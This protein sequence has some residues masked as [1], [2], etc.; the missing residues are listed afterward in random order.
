MMEMRPYQREGVDALWNYFRSGKKGNPLLEY[1]TGCHA[2][3]HGIM[4]ADGSITRV[5]DVR[6]GDKLMGPDSRPRTVLALAR[7]RHVMRR[8]VPTRGES[9][10]VN[11]DHKLNVCRLSETGKARSFE[12]ITIR[13]YEAGSKN[14]RHLR[15]LRRVSIDLPHREQPLR[16]RFVGLMLGDG[17]MAYGLS[18]TSA[19]S[20]LHAYCRSVA[21]GFGIVCREEA[22]PDNLAWTTHFPHPDSTRS[23]PNPLTEVFR[24]LGMWGL[25]AWEKRIPDVY[26]RASRV[27]RLQLLAGL[28]DSDG[29]ISDNNAASYCTTSEGLAQDV[30]YLCRSLGFGATMSSKIAT[31]KGEPKRRAYT[32][33][34][35][36][37][38]GVIPFLRA[39]HVLREW[40]GNRDPLVTAFTTHALPEDDYYGFTLDGDKLYIDEYFNVHHN[41]GKS[42]VIAGFIKEAIER[43][44]RTRITNL[45]DSKHLVGQNAAKLA[46][47]WDG[48]I[49][50][51]SAGLDRKELGS[52]VTFAGTQSVYSKPHVLGHQDMVIVD[53]C[54]M[55]D[56]K[57]KRMYHA[58]LMGMLR[59]NPK[60]R[61]IGLTATPWRQGV[62]H[63]LNGG[64]FTETIYSRIGVDDFNEFVREGYLAD[65]RAIE[66]DTVIDTSKVSTVGGDF[67]MDQLQAASDKEEITRAA[68]E[69]SINNA[70][71]RKFWLVFATGC[72]HVDHVVDMLRSYGISAMGVHSKKSEAENDLAIQM[73]QSGQI[74]ALVNMG[75]LTKGFDAPHTTYIMMLRATKSAVLWVQMLGR[76]TRPKPAWAGHIDCLVGDFGGNSSRLGPINDPL[77]PRK[78]GEDGSGEAPVR[79]CPK[80]VSAGEKVGCGTYYHA[81]LRQCPH[82]G[83][84]APPAKSKLTRKASGADVVRRA[85]E[86]SEMPEIHT[87]PVHS[88]SYAIHRKIGKPD[89]VRVTYGSG[90]RMFSEYLCFEHE[91]FAQ[92]QAQKW[93]RERAERMSL[94]HSM[95]ATA[96]DALAA[97]GE[98]PPAT[99]IRVQV[100]LE[101]PR[102][103]LHCFD[104]TGWGEGDGTIHVPEIAIGARVSGP[105]ITLDELMPKGITED[106]I[107]F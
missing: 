49:G 36:G 14:Y 31:I 54:H 11:L 13:D 8:I 58:L 22:K 81:S 46:S 35:S 102:V 72:E 15:K 86:G 26:L 77:I 91:G 76:G 85:K 9:F 7:G 89:M 61:V 57:P 3:G 88:I 53:E 21:E 73:Y 42:V 43:Y 32:I 71:D 16:P 106:D 105:A 97:I 104:G 62:G 65:L 64:L 20:E 52:S 56:W 47:M 27:Q 2:A 95:P 98:F 75:V 55:I 83:K 33:H 63:I 93:W 92:R 69:E 24:S 1:P 17:S 44:P 66:T 29:Y 25:R 50:I 90:P 28:W 38:F 107:P 30:L 96:A 68:I 60:L 48:D 41:T 101:Y 70:G 45:V 82:C 67:N 23:V 10:V 80:K 78:K 37:D 51:Y 6:V 79:L 5:E 12:T 74:Q 59:V 39:S 99:H 19:D 4:M 40:N 100:N 18:F 84:D 87:F 103:L 34:L 94:D